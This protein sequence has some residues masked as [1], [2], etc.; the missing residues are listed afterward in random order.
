M[1]VLPASGRS[2]PPPPFPLAHVE[3]EERDVWRQLWATPQATEWERL[4]SFYVRVVARYVRSLI[5]AEE[6]G[7]VAA[8]QSEV[9]Q[10]ED[11][12]GLTPMAMLRLRWVIG[13]PEPD[14]IDDD[15][16][17]MTSGH[18]RVAA[19]DLTSTRGEE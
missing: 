16:P 5:E 9:R 13:D 11:R 1:T 2:G 7:A 10:L 14:D 6:P 8:L 4:G 17:V 18:R 12:L 15:V 3:P 19:V